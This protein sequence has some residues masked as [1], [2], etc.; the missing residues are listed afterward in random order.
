MFKTVIKYI[1]QDLP[2]LGESGSEVS[3][4]IQKPRNVAEVTKLSDNIKKNWLE[5]TQKYIK[6]LINNHTFLVQDPEKGEPVNPCM[7]IYKDRIQYDG[8]ID[9]LNLGIMVRGNLKKRNWLDKIGHQHPP[10][11]LW[12]M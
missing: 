5:S 7:D 2:P 11:G 8:S 3:Y 10:W 4:F 12:Y 9:K 1:L 6:T